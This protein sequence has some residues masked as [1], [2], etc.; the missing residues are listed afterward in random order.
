LQTCNLT[1]RPATPA[2]AVPATE[3]HCRSWLAAYT[4]L[5]ADEVIAEKNAVR[6]ATAQ[7]RY[8]KPD[9]IYVGE[10]AGEIVCAGAFL[11]TEDEDLADYFEVKVFYVDPDH[12]RQ[13]IGRQFMDYALYLARAGGYSGVLLYVLEDNH[14]ARRFYESCGFVCEGKCK[15]QNLPPLKNIRY[16][17]R[18]FIAKL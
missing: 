6:R 14:N 16:V 18:D 13:G 3:V 12:F 8:A 15:V 17:K 5:I 10:R 1:F 9:N 2:D 4:G 7:E 11:P